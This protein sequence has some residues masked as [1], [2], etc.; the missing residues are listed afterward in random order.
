MYFNVLVI[1]TIESV[2]VSISIYFNVAEY[3]RDGYE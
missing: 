3:S 2:L 1:V